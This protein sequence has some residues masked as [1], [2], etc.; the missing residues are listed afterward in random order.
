MESVSMLL[1]ESF[2]RRNISR[3]LKELK[4]LPFLI[5]LMKMTILS[6]FSK[7]L[8]KMFYKRLFNYLS[9]HNLLF[10]KQFGF[11]LVQSTQCAIM[12]LID[13]INHK[14]QNNFFT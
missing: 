10:Q 4:L 8:E 5:L 12:E 14:F 1:I 2:R 9:E 13:Q 6:C 7:I 11:Q 3:R